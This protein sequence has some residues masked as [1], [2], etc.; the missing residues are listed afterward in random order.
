VSRNGC[1]IALL[2]LVIPIALCAVSS[3]FLGSLGINTA[4]DGLAK[5]VLPT[6]LLPAEKIPGL[7]GMTNTLLATLLADATILLLFGLGLR[8]LRRNPEDLIPRS[9]IQNLLEMLV[10]GL[11]NLAESVL[12]LKARK[13]FW[14]GATIFIFVLVANWWELVPGFDSVGILEPAHGELTGYEK[15]TFLG[16][17]ALVGPVAGGEPA[18]ASTDE[19]M[20]A[21]TTEESVAQQEEHADSGHVLVPFLRAANTDLNVTIA[22][23]L[24]SV[25]LT[26]FYGIREAGFANYMGRFLQTRRIG[27]GHP[28]GLV[29]V[30]TGLLESVAEFAKIISFAFRLF[31]NIFA[32]QILLFVM[33]FLIPFVFFG[34]LVFYGLEIFVGAIQALVFMM[35][36]FVF[37]AV[38]MAPHGGGHEG[39]H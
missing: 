33:G 36:T 19:S 14:I 24:I 7:G 11:Y 4:L 17:P 31:G 15:G 37:M 25:L 39:E 16:I 22:L 38:A 23:A 2:I 26:Q 28:M 20:E 27:T 30:L 5:P 6:I 18:V 1:L 35:L 13:V 10:E 29:D 9:R 12:G 32:G 3:G 8:Q 21:L 34:I